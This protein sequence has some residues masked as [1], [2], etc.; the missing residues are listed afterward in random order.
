MKAFAAGRAESDT[1]IG[2]LRV[3]PWQLPNEPLRVRTRTTLCRRGGIGLRRHLTAGRSL[4]RV[5]RLGAAR[6]GAWRIGQ[7]GGFGAVTTT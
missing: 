3:P 2:I 4:F 5:H 6:Q 7:R 1:R